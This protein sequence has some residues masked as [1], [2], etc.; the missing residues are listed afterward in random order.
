MSTPLP[1]LFTPSYRPAPTQPREVPEEGTARLVSAQRP[2][3]APRSH[4]RAPC[5]APILQTGRLWLSDWFSATLA[6]LSTCHPSPGC[7]SPVPCHLSWF[8]AA[9]A[10]VPNERAHGVASSIP[11]NLNTSW[12]SGGFWASPAPR[13]P[14]RPGTGQ[15]E[16]TNTRNDLP[17]AS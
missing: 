12:F 15:Q 1:G 11:Q 13:S 10:A 6:C 7:P 3:C 16:E 2:P 9:A 8:P 17:T 5:T 14:I 4:S